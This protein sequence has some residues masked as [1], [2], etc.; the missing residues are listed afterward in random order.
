MRG[1]AGTQCDGGLPRSLWLFLAAGKQNVDLE[2]IRMTVDAHALL[3]EHLARLSLPVEDG[4]GQQF[5]CRCYVRHG[6]LES[7]THKTPES[8]LNGLRD[9]PVLC[10]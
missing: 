4:G 1:R 5:S 8:S 2:G 3:I 9:P 10:E 7:P 6:Q